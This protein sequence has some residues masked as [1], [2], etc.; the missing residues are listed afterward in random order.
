[1]VMFI[2]LA[3]LQAFVTSVGWLVVVRLLLGMPLGSDIS[4]GYTYIIE[5]TPMAKREV[6][7]NR[8]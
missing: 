2:A 3:L 4:N 6:M 5:P 7:D 1:M 8:W